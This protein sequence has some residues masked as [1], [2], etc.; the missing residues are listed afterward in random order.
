M[1][2][3]TEMQNDHKHWLRELDIWN[4]YLRTWKNQQADLVAEASRLQELIEQHGTD[5]EAHVKSIDGHNREIVECE[6]AMVEHPVEG[7]IEVL[8]DVCS[9]H[10]EEARITHE[11][12]KQIHHTLMVQLAVLRHEPFR[13]E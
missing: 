10:H 11:R 7:T 6:R 13:E 12:L 2:Q 1:P 4:S 9:S 8:H 3:P 5:L